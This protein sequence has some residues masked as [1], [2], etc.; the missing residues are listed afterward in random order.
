MTAL[1]EKATDA[2]YIFY[3]LSCRYKL[4]HL[5]VVLCYNID[6]YV[7]YF[8]ILKDREEDE[9]SLHHLKHQSI[10]RLFST[11][12]GAKDWARMDVQDAYRDLA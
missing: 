10:S 9:V 8:F 3:Q 11:I 6:H 1:E 12:T 5:L 4:Y 2:Q 7:L